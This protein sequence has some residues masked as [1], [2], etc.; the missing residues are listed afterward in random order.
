[1]DSPPDVFSSGQARPGDAAQPHHQG[2]D[3]RGVHAGRPGHRRPDHLP[4]PARR[5]R[6]RHDDRRLLRGDPRRAHR[7]QGDLDA[8][9]GRARTADASPP[10][11]TPRAP[12]S[13]RRSATPDPSPTRARRRPKAYAPVRFFNPM[14]MRFAKK[15]TRDD[16]DDIVAAHANAARLADRV[17]LRRRR[18]PSRPQLLRQLVPQPAAQPS[19]RRIRR[20]AGEPRQGGPRTVQ[21]VRRGG[22]ATR[23]R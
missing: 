19:Q 14:S 20:L 9:R 23:S 21:A 8:A 22:A 16:I 18:G 17:R 15:A 6:R 7:G 4:P 1:M 3:V 5:G 12:R 10:R 2:G 11:S 13:A